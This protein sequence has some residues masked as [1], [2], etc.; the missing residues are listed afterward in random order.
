MSEKS[1]AP[2]DLPAKGVDV[3][4][5]WPNVWKAYSALG[6]ASANAGPPDAKP[7]RLIKRWCLSLEFVS[8]SSCMS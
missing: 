6:E 7:T 1:L 2:G 5:S 4:E 3:A 8:V